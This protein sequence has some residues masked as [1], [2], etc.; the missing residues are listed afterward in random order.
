MS[1]CTYIA[2]ATPIWSMSMARE[3]VVGS[4]PT[5]TTTGTRARRASASEVSRFVKPAP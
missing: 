4:P 3:P 2:A 1:V 5:I